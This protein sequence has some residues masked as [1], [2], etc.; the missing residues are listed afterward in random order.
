M[1]WTT[2]GCCSETG[3]YES[4]EQLREQ[5]FR[6][7]GRYFTNLPSSVGSTSEEIYPR[8]ALYASYT[9]G[10]IELRSAVN[11]LDAMLLETLPHAVNRQNLLDRLRPDL[12]DAS[13]HQGL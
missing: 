13:A 2:A 3:G 10:Q 11:Q 6:L 8:Y 9:S 1:A 4:H 12:T 5:F 7:A